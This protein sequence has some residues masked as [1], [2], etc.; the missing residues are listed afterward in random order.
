MLHYFHT[1]QLSE[2]FSKEF[3]AFYFLFVHCR[4]WVF[5]RRDLDKWCVRFAGTDKSV[6]YRTTRFNYEERKER[7]VRNYVILPR[8]VFIAMLVC[9]IY[10]NIY[11]MQ[12]RHL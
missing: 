5:Y 12:F 8:F 3:K 4:P 10:V 7:I 2:S 1:Y 6:A 11:N 9:N